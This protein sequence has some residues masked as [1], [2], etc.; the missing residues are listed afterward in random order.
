MASPLRPDPNERQRSYEQLERERIAHE[1]MNRRGYGAGAF[2]WWWIFW[3]IVIAQEG[4]DR[5]VQSRSFQI[6]IEQD[7]FS[8]A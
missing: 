2:A 6:E 1:R 4:S 5:R 8:S 7:D 3:I